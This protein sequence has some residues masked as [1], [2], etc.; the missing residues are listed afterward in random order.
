MNYNVSVSTTGVGII[1][2]NIV[3]ADSGT[4]I[5]DVWVRTDAGNEATTEDGYYI[6]IHPAGF[7]TVQASS[8]QGGYSTAAQSVSLSAGQTIEANMMLSA[9][10]DNGSDCLFSSLLRGRTDSE[11]KIARFRAFRDQYMSGSE[12]GRRYADLY[13]RYSPALTRMAQRDSRLHSL[14]LQAINDTLSRIDAIEQG[15]LPLYELLQVHSVSRCVQY[16]KKTAPSAL[17]EAISHEYKI[18]R[19]HNCRP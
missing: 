5:D 17:A 12:S 3:D 1:G 6:L 11:K 7:Y 2:G 14:L 19:Q 9:V 15:R 4:G 10:S 13:Y 8:L 16:L 18:S